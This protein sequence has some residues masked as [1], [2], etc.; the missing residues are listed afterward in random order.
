VCSSDLVLG[1]GSTLE[2]RAGVGPH[3]HLE[4][5]ACLTALSSLP[6]GGRIPRGERWDGIPAR[7]AGRAPEVAGTPDDSRRLSP[8]G[9]GLVLGLARFVLG[10]V[11]SLPFQL[12]VIAAA[13]GVDTAEIFNWFTRPRISWPGLLMAAG[14]VVLPVPASL[15]LSAWLARVMGRVRPGVMSRWSLDY[16]RVWLKGDL[17]L[18][19]GRWL[20]GSLWW[21]TWLR[22]AGMAVGRGCEISSIIDTI[23]ELVEIGPESFLADGIYLGGPRL[24]RGTVHLAPVQLGANTFIGN[25]AV[26]CGPQRL[27]A[28][29]L[30]GICTVADEKLMRA[31]TSWFGHPPF[32]LPRREII[33]YDR[34]LTHEPSLVRYA[35]RVFWELLR[36]A[37][38]IVP[39]L[40]T[41]GWCYGMAA[42]RKAFSGWAFFL[43]ATPILALAVP[44]SC[45]LLVLALKWL[46]LGRVRPGLHA[47]WSC[48]CGR[49]DSLYVAWES[50]ARG[51]LTALEGTLW[52]GW[53]LRAMG[54][55]IGRGVIL[56]GGFAQVVDPDM[57]EFED[58]ATVD[59]MFQAHTFEDRVLKIDRVKIRAG[60]TLGHAGVLLYGADI[61]A[62]AR[63]APHSVVMKR[64]HL[65][66]GWAYGGCP[67]RPAWSSVSGGAVG[68]TH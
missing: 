44:A 31:G 56:G 52:L 26:I 20:S 22:C 3:T 24:H 48:W 47:F 2:V 33:Q 43:V 15:T 39:L 29:L 7:T 1:S 14:I 12:L 23:P 66:P 59:C 25:H 13:F 9:H 58:G 17:L 60:A 53:F 11:L 37:T 62:G 57:L 28:D 30:I 18:F 35:T 49:W 27:P 45:C 36:L 5:E 50:W 6:R 34:N 4:P 68:Q 38:L 21:P 16:V 64:E 61:G 32:E 8:E 42:A 67:T 19:A 65:L 46:L 40:T 51:P 10:A 55:R 41:L 54:A 63:V